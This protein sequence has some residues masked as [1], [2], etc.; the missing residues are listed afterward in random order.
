M[1]LR[2]NMQQP[3]FQR[4]PAF[5]GWPAVVEEDGGIGS[6]PV[7]APVP[8]GHADPFPRGRDPVAG[9]YRLRL[10]AAP[11]AHP[12]DAGRRLFLQAGLDPGQFL[13]LLE[14]ISC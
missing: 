7:F 5:S 13:P 3:L 9:V 14:Q 11:P 4:L 2:R 1:L 12:H 6:D 8:E 10:Q